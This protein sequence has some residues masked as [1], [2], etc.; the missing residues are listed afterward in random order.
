MINVISSSDEISPANR[1]MEKNDESIL[2][3]DDKLY[4]ESVRWRHP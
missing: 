2:A 4:N 3:D 1:A